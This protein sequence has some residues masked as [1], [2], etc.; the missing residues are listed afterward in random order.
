MLSHIRTV[1]VHTSHPGNIGSTARAMK[2]MG[3]KYLYLVRPKKFPAAEA[4]AL[5]AGADDI[6]DK[7]KIVDTL[8]MAVKDCSL[9]IGA[10]ARN[11]ALPIPV[12]N[13]REAAE[14]AIAET[15]Q[16]RVAILYGREYAGLSNEELERCHFHIQIPTN[17]KYS[18][19]NLAAAVQV[20]SYEIRVALKGHSQNVDDKVSE[21]RELVTADDMERFY[22]RLDE[23]LQ[24]VNFIN[25]HHPNRIMPRL[26]RLY[27]R[28]R[29]DKNELNIL[30]GILTEVS[31][32]LEL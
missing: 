14:K 20:I 27:N 32:K 22:T 23:V 16:G 29:V 30:R 7:A 12:L 21:E 15:I 13:P 3:L 26:R 31:K 2:T 5:A 11:R 4:S 10:S 28:A 25:P 17:P 18:S 19:L 6:L 1:L 8:D 24:A 9:I